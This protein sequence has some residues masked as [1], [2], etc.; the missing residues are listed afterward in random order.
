MFDYLI[1]G[2]GVAGLSAGAH[3]AP[4]AH[5]CLLEA[6]AALGHHASSRSAAVFIPAYGGEAVGPLSRASHE[7]LKAAG[8]LSPRGVMIVAMA[9]EE[10]AFETGTAGYGLAEVSPEDA[11][12]HC[13]LLD[14]AKLARVGFSPDA[15]D[16]DTD[17]LLQGYARTIR[18]SGTIHTGA[19]VS[20]ITH[21]AP[22]HWRVRAGEET[23]EARALVNA[24]GA[25]A[26]EIA[27][28]AGIAPIGLTPKRR[29]MARISVP[30]DL[31]PA[32]WPI[33]FGAS[34]DW[35]AKPDAGALIVSPSE[36]DPTEPHDAWADDM[37]LATGLARFEERMT[38][39][40]TRL[41]A[42]WAGLRTFSPDGALVIGPEPGEPDF[43]WSAGQGGSGFKTG[44]AAG[45]LL[46]AHALGLAPAV[47]DAVVAANSPARFRADRP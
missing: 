17:A 13:P 16:I 38:H 24:A 21:V 14:P 19:R 33:I 6:E 22:G 15:Q 45:A 3:L 36:A 9:G 5:V 28:L 12:R 30:G 44:P 25:W 4:H 8:V 23:L 40:V 1:I 47:A 43:F 46:A 37:V 26:D 27:R 32:S 2:G 10:A 34:N 7:A 42:N 41:L 31:D 29:S 11:A 18:A 39:P 35:Y 20:E